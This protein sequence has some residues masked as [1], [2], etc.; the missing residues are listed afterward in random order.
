MSTHQ[1]ATVA[2]LHR[3]VQT[4]TALTTRFPSLQ[5]RPRALLAIWRTTYVAAITILAASLPFFGDLMGLV[6]AIGALAP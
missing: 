3:C 6:G 5:A 2:P 4:E 1:G